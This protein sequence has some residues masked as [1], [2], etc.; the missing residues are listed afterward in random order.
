MSGRLQSSSHAD[1][2]RLLNTTLE[3]QYTSQIA[4]LDRQRRIFLSQFFRDMRN[5]EEDSRRRRNAKLTDPIPKRLLGDEAK[6]NITD[7]R[8]VLS[9]GRTTA[10]ASPRDRLR[11]RQRSS[12]EGDLAER[13]FRHVYKDHSH[14]DSQDVTE[15]R[16]SPQSTSVSLGYPGRNLGRDSE[17][18]EVEGH[19]ER[20]F[21][22]MNRSRRR[23]VHFEDQKQIESDHSP[24]EAWSM[25]E[26]TA[27]GH[28]SVEGIPAGNRILDSARALAVYRRLQRKV[29]DSLEHGN[30]SKHP[31]AAVESTMKLMKRRQ[32]RKMR[33][34][35]A[36]KRK[37]KPTYAKGR[38]NLE[39]AQKDNNSKSSNTHA[40]WNR[41]QRRSSSPSN[42]KE[43]YALPSLSIDHHEKGTAAKHLSVT[44][45]SAS[46]KLKSR[47]I[48]ERET[49]LYFSKL[50]QTVE[51]ER[52]TKKINAYLKTY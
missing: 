49:K 48:I 52:V 23:K 8:E 30:K 7:R 12:S 39:R 40:W 36:E 6:S 31:E 46:N 19:V 16:S 26:L 25:T 27:A 20:E 10:S 47:A 21:T 29:Q 11:M 32:Q 51:N 18:G 33:E 4:H 3:K 9:V 13:R 17:S 37:G 2:L 14:L 42:R 28:E 5:V 44:D 15:A 45:G 35:D 38:G 24:A 1:K 22:D 41:Q 34:D 50:E 43:A